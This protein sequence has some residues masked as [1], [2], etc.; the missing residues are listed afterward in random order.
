MRKNHIDI[1]AEGNQG[2]VFS[3]TYQ[4]GD[5]EKVMKVTNAL[6]SKFIEENIRFR[7]ERVTETSTY[8]EDELRMAKE[9]LDQKEEKMR[10]YKLKYYNEMPDQREVNM[11]R[12]NVLQGRYNTTQNN[13]HN[14]EQTRLIL[15]E[16]ISLQNSLLGVGNLAGQGNAG[17]A[18][19]SGEINDLPTARMELEALLAK[20]T[21]Q[22]PDVKRLK[23]HIKKLEE[24]EQK[25]KTATTKSP[26]SNLRAQSSGQSYSS[27]AQINQLHLQVKE[28]EMGLQTS[29]DELFQIQKEIKKYQDW[30][31]AVP[32]REAE[33]NALTR[34][35]NELRKHYEELVSQSLAAESAES[36]ER[37]QKGS[38]FK[39]IDPAYF[40]QKP[41]K[42]NFYEIMAIAIAASLGVCLGLIISL[43]TLDTSFREAA[44]IEKYLDIPVICS[45]PFVATR[46]EKKKRKLR[47]ILWGSAFAMS[48]IVI[49]ICLVFYWHKGVIIL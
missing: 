31:D 25:V 43:D 21:D 42:P 39:I 6:A 28:I 33:W 7:E 4:G 20:Y 15:L 1:K 49:A 26:G 3:V 37:R 12:L 35:Y 34:D 47:S 24:Q 45:I 46:D 41:S 8:V 9:K 2:Y 29:K 22:H 48:G 40:P 44:D 18:S 17:P 14:M 23:A 32:V 36:L 11:S 30:I 19:Q 13:I 10:D 27:N 5:P 16:Q 38:Q